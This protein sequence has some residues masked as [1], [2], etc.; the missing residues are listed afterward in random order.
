MRIAPKADSKRIKDGHK[1]KSTTPLFRCATRLFLYLCI[2]KAIAYFQ[3]YFL[4]LR[5]SPVALLFFAL[6]LSSCA[7]KPKVQPLVELAASNDFEQLVGWVGNYPSLNTLTKEKAHS[8]VY[9]T[10]VRPSMDFS[11]SF[12]S[13]LSAVSMRRPKKI[14]VSAWVLLP[15]E[16]ANAKLVAEIK[17]ADAAGTMLFYQATELAKEVKKFNE[18]QQV[19]KT[20]ELPANVPA[21]GLLQIYMWRA[22]SNEPVFMDDIKISVGN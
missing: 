17:T 15:S 19:E 18:W 5:S 12:S 7:D 8:G 2:G 13:A 9:S 20:I 6:V 10:T 16:Q 21:T 1:G 4:M 11:I 3:F 22:G 14:I